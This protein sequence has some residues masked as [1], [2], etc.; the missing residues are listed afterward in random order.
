MKYVEG[1]KCLVCLALGVVTFAASAR[2]WTQIISAQMRVNNPTVMDV[3]YIV[4]GGNADGKV[5]VRVLAFENGVRSFANVLRPTKFLE[6]SVVGNGVPANA[7]NS[8]AWQVSADWAVD[9]AKVTVEVLAKDSGAELV[10]LDLVTIPAHDSFGVVT[11]ST[12]VVA[13]DDYR[14]ALYWLYADDDKELSLMDGWLRDAD[15]R[16]L[17]KGNELQGDGFA[18]EF[19]YGKMGFNAVGTNCRFQKG[20]HHVVAGIERIRRV[21]MPYSGNHRYAVKGWTPPAATSVGNGL[22]MVI[23]LNAAD[24]HFPVTYLDSTPAKWSDE[25]KTNK[26]VLRRFD[27]GYVGVFEITEA[28][29]NRVIAMDSRSSSLLPVHDPGLSICGYSGVDLE[30]SGY[31]GDGV[32]SGSLSDFFERLRLLTGISSFS[33]PTDS[34]D[35]PV[36][37]I[38]INDDIGDYAWFSANSNGHL[39][40]VGTRAADSNGLYDVCGNVA[41]L[42]ACSWHDDSEGPNFYE[43]V[44]GGSYASEKQ[45]LGHGKHESYPFCCG[46]DPSYS[47]KGFR[48]YLYYE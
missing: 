3:E 46:G 12:N 45:C 47:A 6:G 35:F 5:D 36:S 28:Q 26:I 40:P 18:A 33:L 4:H 48:L 42:V 23:D 10:P 34:S 9:L 13:D 20:L 31:G 7:T 41:E 30:S 37:D 44:Q 15:G 14:A 11:C 1:M 32:V 24:Y 25:Y 27:T 16:V 2:P 8:F 21:S 38:P 19:I 43:C 29:W 22:Y 17:A 39:H